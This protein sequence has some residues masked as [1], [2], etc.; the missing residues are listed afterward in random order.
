MIGSG[1]DGISFANPNQEHNLV[2]EDVN[3]IGFTGDA[4][5]GRLFA[6]RWNRMFI[7]SNLGWGATCDGTFSWTDSWFTQSIFAGNVAGG[8]NF[9]STAH[10]GEVTFVGCRFERSGW[11]PGAPTFPVSTSAPGIRIAGSLVGASFTECST[12][13]NSGNG[14]EISRPDTSVDMHHIQFTACRFNRDG[15]GTMSGGS[16][17][18]FAEVKITGASGAR[19]GYITF[20]NCVTTEGHADDSGG[21]PAYFHA[22]YGLWWTNVDYCTWLGGAVSDGHPGGR[23]NF[24]SVWRPA[25]DIAGG[26]A[27]GAG[28][29]AIPVWT[30]G[31]EPPSPVSGQLGYNESTHKLVAFNA[32]TSIWDV[33]GP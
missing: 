32:G 8:L 2:A 20:A 31:S 12:D 1:I 16:A 29:L 4:I 14:V 7:G 21:N 18:D 22:K 26:G 25:I 11:N 6:T 9:S 17:P 28:Q 27:S 24:S 10:S 30:A 15:F 19:I 5:R 3:I 23:L 33:I 13:A